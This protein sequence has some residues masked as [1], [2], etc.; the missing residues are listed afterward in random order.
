M[1]NESKIFAL[2]IENCL[3]IEYNGRMAEGDEK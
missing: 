2:I 3:M 1:R